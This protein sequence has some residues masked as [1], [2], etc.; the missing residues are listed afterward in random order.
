MTLQ[1]EASGV[2]QAT[3]KSDDRD[4]AEGWQQ[5]LTLHVRT[6]TLHRELKAAEVA[7]AEEPSDANFA[8][9]NEIR[10]ELAKSE[11]TEAL[12]EGFGASSGRERPVF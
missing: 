5:A 4:A 11:G 10:G 6:G 7:L 2:W 9:I 12:I 1:V 3:A 8:R